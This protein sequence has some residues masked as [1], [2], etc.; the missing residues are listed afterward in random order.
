M[1]YFISLKMPNNS[2]KY[3]RAK[4]LQSCPTLCDPMDYHP[5]RLLCPRNFPGKSTGVGCHALLQGIFPTQGWNPRLLHLLLWQAGSLPLAPPGK[6]LEVDGLDLLLERRHIG[7]T[8]RKSCIFTSLSVWKQLLN[9]FLFIGLHWVLVVAG[10]IS[11]ASC[12][13]CYCSIGIL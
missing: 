3:A 5:C 12:W 4:S 11:V 1:I 2:F 9:K 6:H 7:V 8:G 10:S 13:I